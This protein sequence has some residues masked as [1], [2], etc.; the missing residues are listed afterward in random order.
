LPSSF[1]TLEDFT[2]PFF[3]GIIFRRKRLRNPDIR[4]DQVLRH[5]LN[6]GLRSLESWGVLKTGKH[7]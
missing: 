7:L 5:E 3:F 4:I 2:K 6:V 1:E